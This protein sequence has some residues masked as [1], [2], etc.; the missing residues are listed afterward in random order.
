M[1]DWSLYRLCR[2][3]GIVSAPY[4]S[5]SERNFSA[6][7]NHEAIIPHIMPITDHSSPIPMVIAAP[8]NA[9]KSQA[10]SPDAL[11]EKAVTQGL[12]D[13]PAKS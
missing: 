12:R 4:L 7:I 11:S 8:G 1:F 6:M 5:V 10:D 3:S 13:L 9:N 2:Y